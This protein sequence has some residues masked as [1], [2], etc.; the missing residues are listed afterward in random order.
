M[1]KVHQIVNYIIVN[2]HF[3]INMKQQYKINV[4]DLNYKNKHTFLKDRK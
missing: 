2:N 1:Y 3:N 4:I